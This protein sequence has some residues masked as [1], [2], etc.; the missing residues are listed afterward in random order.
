MV[1][2]PAGIKGERGIEGL[3]GKDG[4]D[5]ITGLRGPAGPVGPIGPAGRAGRG[6]EACAITEKGKLLF[7]YTDGEVVSV[8]N[9]KGPQG[10]TGAQGAPGTKGADGADG[11][12]WL[13]G[14]NPPAEGDGNVG[15]HW[16]DYASPKLVLYKKLPSGWSR[17]AT[18]RP[19]QTGGGGSINTNPPAPPT[20]DPEAGWDPIP[21][22]PDMDFQTTRTLPLVD[23]LTL[24]FGLQPTPG[25]F[26]HSSHP[27][28][29]PP[30][31]VD[32]NLIPNNN[33]L[34]DDP[35]TFKNQEQYNIWVYTNFQKLASLLD[36]RWP[37]VDGSDSEGNNDQSGVVTM[38]LDG[39]NAG[40]TE[41][42][43]SDRVVDGGSRPCPQHRPHPLAHCLPLSINML[44]F[45]FG[46]MRR[47]NGKQQR[48]LMPLFSR[49]KLA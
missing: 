9:I 24:P 36:V 32:G 15:D 43:N 34:Y 13:S 37:I 48:C 7:E 46:V 29:W 10:L 23:G 30:R 25:G 28:V 6:V 27:G 38:I 47:P 41:I 11:A 14:P 39:D 17:I 26:M 21:D 5:G 22:R 4:I 42:P 2:M 19:E 33:R 16:L 18:M 20:P 12:G 44:A 1:T 45:R 3:P 40:L 8:G 35:Y 49:V 31:D